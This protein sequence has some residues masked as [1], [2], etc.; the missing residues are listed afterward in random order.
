MLKTTSLFCF[1]SSN[2]LVMYSEKCDSFEIPKRDFMTLKGSRH[3]RKGQSFEIAI[4]NCIVDKQDVTLLKAGREQS[5][6]FR[7]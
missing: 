2:K 4:G 6:V 7:Q 5:E 3:R 1:A